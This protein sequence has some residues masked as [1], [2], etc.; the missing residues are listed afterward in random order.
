MHVG[1]EMSQEDD[2]PA[3]LT[4]DAFATNLKFLRIFPKLRPGCAMP[5]SGE[6]T[7]MR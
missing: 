3:T 4:Q 6:E 1:A 2:C 7:K 5:L